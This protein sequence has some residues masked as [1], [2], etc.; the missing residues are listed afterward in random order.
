MKCSNVVLLVVLSVWEATC[1]SPLLHHMHLPTKEGQMK[2]LCRSPHSFV[3]RMA[4]RDK[5]EYIDVKIEEIQARTVR[6]Q[7]LAEIEAR[8]MEIAKQIEL[9]EKERNKLLK[10]AEKAAKISEPVMTEKSSKEY[11]NKNIKLR[12]TTE[13]KPSTA[14]TET[15]QYSPATNIQPVT[16]GP[17]ALLC[18]FVVAAVGARVALE[19]RDEKQQELMSSKDDAKLATEPSA[20]ITLGLLT[21][22]NNT[23]SEN[24][25]EVITDF[26]LGKKVVG[27]QLNETTDQKEEKKYTVVSA[28]GSKT[29][30]ESSANDSNVS[31]GKEIDLIQHSKESKSENDASKPVV[32]VSEK[33]PIDETALK[34]V[35]RTIVSENKE[36]DDLFSSVK[37]GVSDE[38]IVLNDSFATSKEKSDT[39]PPLAD[40]KVDD[41]VLKIVD[42]KQPDD[43]VQEVSSPRKYRG[44]ASRS[45]LFSK[46][47]KVERESEVVLSKDKETVSSHPIR[48]KIL[49][50]GDGGSYA[51]SNMF[52]ARDTSEIECWSV[53]TDLKSL[54]DAKQK[55]ARAFA[56]GPSITKGS[57]TDGDPA[58]GEIAAIE[59]SGDV[60]G[61]INGANVCIITSGLG[62]GTGSGAA[63]IISK[64]AKDCGAL[65][66]AVV[67]EPFP[68]EGKKRTRQAVEAIDR[69]FDRADCVIVISNSNVLEIIPE[70]SSL[71]MSFQVV[72]EIVNQVVL[73]L[74]DLFTKS[75]IVTVDFDNLSNIFKGS[76][77]AVIGMGTGSE[78]SAAEDAAYA[79][80]SSPLINAPLDKARA[81]VVNIVGG[82]ELS[83][84][85]IK[86]VES[87]VRANINSDTEVLFGAQLNE[88]LPD[89]TVSVTIIATRFELKA[90]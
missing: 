79:A 40:E 71:D 81:V 46:S 61:M 65:T 51:M 35:N 88:S 72:D 84:E 74:T 87:V 49:G 42:L 55:G 80:L 90:E 1:F 24:C 44:S 47:L 10:E 39:T 23:E 69:L 86:Q 73:G 52:G 53:N 25:T 15:K 28:R 3:T 11:E 54:E 6:E 9:A 58:V 37:S 29:V 41:N 59:S 27:G 77:F 67:T 36:S 63:P 48:V 50:V 83:P 17:F 56:I 8:K 4:S 12:M 31:G 13:A 85:K 62:S 20:N 34:N 14:V 16:D 43:A 21:G 66:I 68:F 26:F 38:E 75:G 22:E 18:G 70:E 33:S 2:A 76:G 32:A 5:G 60:A 78:D 45:G 30:G 19:N 7:R 57:G 64:L 89:S 82:K